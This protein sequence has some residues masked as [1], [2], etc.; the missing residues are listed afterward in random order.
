MLNKEELDCSL[1]ELINNIN[2]LYDERNVIFWFV[3]RLKKY[4]SFKVLWGQRH[5]YKK[6]IWYNN[7]NLV[8]NVILMTKKVLYAF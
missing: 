4:L 2:F 7:I 8:A 1:R 6:S 3:K 5:I